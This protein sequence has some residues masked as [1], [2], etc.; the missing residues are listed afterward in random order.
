MQTTIPPPSYRLPSNCEPLNAI[1][2]DMEC[3]ELLEGIVVDTNGLCFTPPFINMQKQKR[4]Q[5][6]C[7][8]KKRQTETEKL[9]CQ[10]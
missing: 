3:T 1:V 5:R 8:A 10:F 7:L 4:R 6:H 2:L 9:F